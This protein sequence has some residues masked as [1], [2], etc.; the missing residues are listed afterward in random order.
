MRNHSRSIIPRKIYTRGASIFHI[1]PDRSF[2]RAMKIERDETRV[3][4]DVSSVQ[5]KVS[6][7]VVTADP[8][9]I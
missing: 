8:R 1:H 6:P 2:G 7:I 4:A 5:T 9:E 3:Y